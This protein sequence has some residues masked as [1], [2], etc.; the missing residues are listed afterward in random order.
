M[1]RVPRFLDVSVPLAPGVPTYP[2]NPPFE[3]EPVKRIANGDSVQRVAD[4]DRHAHRHARRRAAALLSTTAPGVD[5]L[6]LDLL[7]GRA[8]VVDI[9][10]R[11][12]ITAERPRPLP[13]LRE[14]LRVLLKTPNSALWN[15]GGPFTAGLHAT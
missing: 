6:S 7:I 11:G 5:A 14:D 12:G 13:G 10:R 9:P 4:G 15:G 2:G 1:A 3:F 8:R